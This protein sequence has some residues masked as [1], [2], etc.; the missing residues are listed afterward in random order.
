MARRTDSL[1]A[2]RAV[3]EVLDRLAFVGVDRALLRNA[4]TVPPR[5]LRSLDALHLATALTTR[6][7]VDV[8]VVY[9][10]RL[11]QAARAVGLSVESPGVP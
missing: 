9:D 8:F 11:A 10:Q 1:R 2:K 6:E 4:A 3:A 7:W 5:G